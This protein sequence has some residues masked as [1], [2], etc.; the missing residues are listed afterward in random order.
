MDVIRH[1]HLADE[2]DLKSVL[3]V[4]Q[5]LDDDARSPTFVENIPRRGYRLMV[6]AEPLKPA[7]PNEE[8]DLQPAVPP[9][10]PPG[11]KWVLLVG[12]TAVLIIYLV[13]VHPYRTAADG[14]LA[15]FPF[16][17]AEEDRILCYG[18]SEELMSKLL[19]AGGRRVV[20]SRLHYPKEPGRQ[21]V[22][23]EFDIELLVLGRLTR[24]AENVYVNMEV[25]NRR[26][27]SSKWT[28][29]Q[30]GLLS[31]VIAIRSRITSE[32]VEFILGK[33]ALGLEGPSQPASF[34][35]LE[36][37]TRGQYEFS[38]RSR[39]SLERAIEAFQ[40]TIRLDDRFGPAYLHL[41]YAYALTPEYS[42]APSS[43]MYELA[44]NAVQRGVELD[45]SVEGPAQSV[46][47][48]IAHKQ[49][50]WTSAARAHEKAIASQPVY[51]ISHQL[52]SRLLA[53]TGRLHASLR[54][55]ERARQIDPQQAVLMSR[56]AMA[57]FWLDDLEN[58]GRYFRQSNDHDEYEAP[59]HDL[60]YA[61]FLVRTGQFEQ[62]AAAAAEGLGKD[63]V[64][65]SWIPGVFYTK[66]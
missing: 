33:D 28:R 8:P 52:Y 9:P 30:Q 54:E 66:Q 61:L 48:F 41:A 47:G 58:A 31:N 40:E 53:S 43:Q 55:A 59:I 10:P 60:A 1:D 4:R 51:P 50:L 22:A 29:S 15:V 26:D 37:Y 2:A 5:S 42:G 32:A 19:E 46:Y 27:G 39:E 36:A 17:C 7:S 62:A 34:E 11:P 14:S 24:D 23:D 6:E 56:L 21:T 25:I 49:N 63:N 57:Y 16:D 12:F 64:D 45:P 44:V 3:Q 20:R 35:A 18:F 65:A 13:F 38:V